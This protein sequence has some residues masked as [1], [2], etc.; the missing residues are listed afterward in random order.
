M[1]TPVIMPK[2]EMSQETAT[3]VAWLKAEGDT[4]DKGEPLLT[5]E[6]DKVT[7]D[8]E[9]PAAGTLADVRVQADDVV[10]VTEVIAQIL[11]PGESLPSHPVANEK[12]PHSDKQRVTPVAQRIAAEHALSLEGVKGT[13]V[14]GRITKADVEAAVRQVRATP[15]ARRIAR[16]RGVKLEAIPGSGPRG[17]IQAADVAAATFPK[18]LSFREGES[19][20]EVIPLAG[21]R[22]TIAERMTHSAQSAPHITLTVEADTSA[23]Q[24]LRAE[25]NA[26][27]EAMEV[28][29]LSITAILVKACAWALMRH[30]WVNG[31]LHGDEIHLHPSA[32]VGVA[33][34]LE[35]GLIVPVIHRA[36]TLGLGEIS[37]R[38]SEL[39]ERA[40]QGTLSPADVSEG[41]FTL[42]NLGMYGI[43]QF[44]AILNPPQAAILAVGSIAK[45][46]VVVERDEQDA[47]AIRPMMSMTLSADHRVLDG[48]VAA[49]FLQ[50][51]VDVL[52]HPNL[53]LW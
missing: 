12:A 47:V 31:S 36:E 23:V 7:I 33:V 39:A 1:P 34:A 8:I 43:R 16:E 11:Q 40:Q 35:E 18:A 5:V 13:G 21:M 28:P 25:L 52:E 48:A 45:R 17:R 2:L 3:V 53:L 6:T 37:A 42:S 22:R 51:L 24:A 32:N 38:L 9:S 20:V 10:P 44:T 46:Q 29:R 30:R 50:D 19:D 27:A 26:R 49:R 14:S 15:A 4:V 41:T